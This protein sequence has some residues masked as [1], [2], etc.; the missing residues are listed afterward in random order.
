[1]R[2]ETTHNN[3]CCLK[4]DLDLKKG[5]EKSKCELQYPNSSGFMDV[6]SYFNGKLHS[7]EVV[8]DCDSNICL[9]VRSC[10]I[11]AQGQV[12][13]LT[14]VTLLKSEH[15]KILETI[16]SDPELVFY[17]NKIKFMTLEDILKALYESC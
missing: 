4:R 7:T 9:H 15:R 17:I 13:E 11:E 12:E 3:V 10:F 14:V 1:M 5:A 16:M 2:G 8:I 6:G